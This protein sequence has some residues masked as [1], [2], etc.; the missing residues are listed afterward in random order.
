MKAKQLIV[1]KKNVD[2]DI[3]EVT[4]L[5]AKEYMAAKKYI[6]ARHEWGF[7]LRSFDSGDDRKVGIVNNYGT[8][9][10]VYAQYENGGVSPALRIQNLRSFNLIPGEKAEL[11]GYTWTVIADDLLLC[12][13]VVGYTRFRKDRKAKDANDYE[14]S[15]IKKWLE[16]WAAEN[17]I[18]VNVELVTA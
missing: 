6:P 9:S 1:T 2:L 17:G 3:A 15:D 7:W 16:A 14:A 12:D 13:D 4:L 11:A 18:V 5:S 8:L 10:L